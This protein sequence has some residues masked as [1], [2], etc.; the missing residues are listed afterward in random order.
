MLFPEPLSMEL[1]FVIVTFLGAWR[2]YHRL[3]L[4][5]AQLLPAVIGLALSWMDSPVATH[6]HYLLL[7]LPAPECTMV[8]DRYSLEWLR[9]SFT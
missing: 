8:N 5:A 3:P 7:I 4:L 9:P 6:S 1:N 2:T